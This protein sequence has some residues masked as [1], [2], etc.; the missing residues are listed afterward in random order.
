MFK[1]G[2][3]KENINLHL[4]IVEKYIYL[5]FIIILISK[6]EEKY[7]YNVFIYHADAD[8]EIALSMKKKLTEEN[9]EVFINADTEGNQSK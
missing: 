3:R 7:V 6:S 1:V 4:K 5:L 2:P 9:Y 8:N